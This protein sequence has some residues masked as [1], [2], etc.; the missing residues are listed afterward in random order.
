[1]AAAAVADEFLLQEEEAVSLNLSRVH[2]KLKTIARNLPRVAKSQGFQVRITSGWRSYQTQIKLYNDWYRGLSPYPVARP[3]TSKHEK[4][5][6]LDI[7]STNT[8]AL[9]ALLNSVGLAWGG[10]TDPVHFEIPSGRA[11][12][13]PRTNDLAPAK[14][15]PKASFWE[16][17]EASSKSIVELVSW[18]PNPLGLSAAISQLF[19]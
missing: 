12:G 10:P 5:L 19:W 6:A 13:A 16:S 2:P 7:L 14:A 3:G 9:V 11:V 4:G 17:F 15:I 1:V 18:L 8:E